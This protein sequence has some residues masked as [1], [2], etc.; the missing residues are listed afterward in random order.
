MTISGVGRKGRGGERKEASGNSEQD[1]V[2]SAGI[3]A[4]PIRLKQH[5]IPY[6]AYISRV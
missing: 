3:L 6:G 4:E 1:V 5:V 2:G